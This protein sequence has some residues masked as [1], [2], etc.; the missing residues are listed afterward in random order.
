MGRCPGL[1]SFVLAWVAVAE[2]A[3]VVPASGPRHAYAY[4]AMM[5][6]PVAKS[7]TVLALPSNK[8]S[9]S[10]TSRGHHCS[11][12]SVT[13]ISRPKLVEVV[14]G[15]LGVMKLP[16]TC[17]MRYEHSASDDAWLVRSIFLSVSSYLD[18]ALCKGFYSF[19]T[20][21]C[22]QNALLL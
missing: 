15:L 6:G 11:S 12:S 16:S 19:A 4:A 22:R 21:C 5:P 20:L 17:A 13:C 10:V 8:V 2:A 7:Q 14:D 1:R 18:S 3:A 9:S